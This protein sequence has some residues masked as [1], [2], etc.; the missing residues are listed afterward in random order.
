MWRELVALY[1]LQQL[2]G[3]QYEEYRSEDRS[4]RQSEVDT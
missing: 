2:G 3:V 1:Q 4:L